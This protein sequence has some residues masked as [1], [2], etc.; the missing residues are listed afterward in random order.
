MIVDQRFPKVLLELPFLVEIFAQVVAEHSVKRAYPAVPLLRTLSLLPALAQ[1][2]LVADDAALREQATRIK[3]TASSE[4][5]A[6]D[7]AKPPGLDIAAASLT[8]LDEPNIQAGDWLTLQLTV[9]RRHV[10]AGRIAPLAAT[11]YDQVDPTSPFRLDNVWVVVMEK[12]G[13]RLYAAWKVRV[14]HTEMAGAGGSLTGCL[15]CS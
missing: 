10:A 12:G 4:D 3:A 9:Q 14:V 2:S 11:M 7:A 13:G 15:S 5:T 6:G 8:V 1:G